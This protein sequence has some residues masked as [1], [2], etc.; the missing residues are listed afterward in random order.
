MKLWGGRFGGQTDEAME[1]LGASLYV[2]WRL[3]EADIHGSMAYA[4]ALTKVGILT[5]A[6]CVEINGGWG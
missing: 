2:D 6:E 5:A 4:R 3:H 1:R